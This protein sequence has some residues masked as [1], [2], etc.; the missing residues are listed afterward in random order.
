MPRNPIFIIMLVAT[1]LSL[2]GCGVI[3]GASLSAVIADSIPHSIGGLPPA[4]PPRPSDAKYAEYLQKINGK[5][6]A[7]PEEARA[8]D[9]TKP[10][11][12][13]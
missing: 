4:I 12:G 5:A 2:N 6:V 13:E 7:P 8:L 9:E 10:Q 1:A 3:D 11:S